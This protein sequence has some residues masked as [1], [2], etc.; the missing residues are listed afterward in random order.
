MRRT[1]RVLMTLATCAVISPIWAD[2]RM[3]TADFKIQLNG[4]N[5][6]ALLGE[7]WYSSEIRKFLLSNPSTMEKVAFGNSYWLY[8]KDKGI[9][10]QFNQ[11][12]R[13]EAIRVFGVSKPL[14]ECKRYEG[15]L[16]FGLTI[17]SR[18][19]AVEAVLGT[20]DA[21][22]PSGNGTWI[23]FKKIGL[24]ITFE[25]ID[26]TDVDPPIHEIVASKR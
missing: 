11:W 23:F 5:A 12:D 2:N 7:N 25:S 6:F 19:K 13:L 8:L 20:P 4:H 26:Q 9:I 24:Q 21:S 15:R 18:R 14:W 22:G 10:F 3:S 1:R 17:S 16:P